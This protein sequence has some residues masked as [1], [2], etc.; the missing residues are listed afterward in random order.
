M[1]PGVVRQQGIALLHGLVDEGLGG[2][3]VQRPEQCQVLWQGLAM[4]ER[5]GDHAALGQFG[6]HPFRVDVAPEA[7]DELVFLAAIEV[8][9]AL[10]VEMA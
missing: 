9:V 6:L 4:H 1:D 3:G 7:G 8:Q 2:S 5:L 10:L